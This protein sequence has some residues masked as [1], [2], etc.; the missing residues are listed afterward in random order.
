MFSLFQVLIGFHGRGHHS[1]RRLSTYYGVAI[2]LFIQIVMSD[3]VEMEGKCE[4]TGQA[5]DGLARKACRCSHW[6]AVNARCIRK[7]FIRDL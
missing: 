4:A 3:C 2:Q 6:F 1:R 5:E 7:I